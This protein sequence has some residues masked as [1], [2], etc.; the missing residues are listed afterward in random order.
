MAWVSIASS[1]YDPDSPVTTTLAGAWSNNPAAMAAGDSGAPEIV[2]AALSATAVSTKMAAA[3]ADSIGSYAF[4]TGFSPG[5]G[6]KN[7][8]DLASGS[9]LR[10]AG[11]AGAGGTVYASSPTPSGTWRCMGYLGATA[12]AGDH[13]SLF[14][15]VS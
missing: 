6:A 8:G 1:D 5:L 13:V 4:M 3:A 7:P 12:A 11:T 9:D 15:R 14:L 2:A 10:F